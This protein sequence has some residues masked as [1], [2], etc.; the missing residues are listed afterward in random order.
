VFDGGTKAKGINNL[1]VDG[2]TYD[3]EFLLAVPSE[4][5][6]NYPGTYT[7]K[8]NENAIVAIEAANIALNDTKATV[9]GE[10]G[11]D[12][13]GRYRVG[14]QS[15][16]TGGSENTR[17]KLGWFEPASWNVGAEETNPYNEE[18]VTWAV[19]TEK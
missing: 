9:V 4:I 1:V 3:V 14:Y 5:Y 8:T 16:D 15:F 18:P 13:S 10:E 7:F 2:V 12:G 11:Q 19:F 17:F 6:G